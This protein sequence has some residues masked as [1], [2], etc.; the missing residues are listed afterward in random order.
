MNGKNLIFKIILSIFIFSLSS[1]GNVFGL[2][3]FKGYDPNKKQPAYSVSAMLKMKYR[4]GSKWNENYFHEAQFQDQGIM[5]FTNIIFSGTFMGKKG[6]K[7]NSVITF[8]DGEKYSFNRDFG[9]DEFVI[10]DDIFGIKLGDNGYARLLDDNNYVLSLDDPVNDVSME[11]TYRIINPPQIFGDGVVPIDGR[12][13]LSYSQPVCGAIVSGVLHYHGKTI[14]LNGRGSIDHDYNCASPLLQPLKYRSFWLYND[15]YSINI[16]TAILKN[17]D[18]IDR[19]SVFKNGILYKSF[20]N[21]GLEAS[22]YSYDNSTKFSYPGSFTI[23]HTDSKGDSITAAI[24]VMK[25]TDK[26]QCFKE[27]STLVHAIVV[28]AVGEM[29]AYR[30]WV[31]AEFS[32]N[33][34]NKVDTIKINGTC[35]YVDIA[36]E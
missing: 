36:R 5:I 18:E 32:L 20:L 24:K 16:H 1:A 25:L 2:E 17:K 9:P 6:C 12:N 21:T 29:W 26:I 14:K 30:F 4:D 23:D 22:D 3:Y 28:R 7:L 27:L 35:N 34:G 15:M 19:V 13:F 10:N 8:S 31:K 33:V 11:L